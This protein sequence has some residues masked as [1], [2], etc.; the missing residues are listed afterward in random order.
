MPRPYPY[1]IIY[2]L[3]L[4]VWVG[5]MLGGF[6]NFIT[7]LLVFGLLPLLRRV[8]RVEHP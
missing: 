5:Y 7:P 1:F 8:H 6:Y 4:A 2:L 3:P